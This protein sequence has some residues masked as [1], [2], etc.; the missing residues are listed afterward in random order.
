MKH[1]A[2]KSIELKTS[3][4]RGLGRQMNQQNAEVMK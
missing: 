3:I 1:E 2:E 4:W